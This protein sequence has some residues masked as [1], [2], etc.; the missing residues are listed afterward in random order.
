MRSDL[1]MRRWPALLGAAAMLLAGAAANAKGK[2][3]G[4]AIGK[5]RWDGKHT[6]LVWMKG[7]YSTAQSYSMQ[8]VGLV[9]EHAEGKVSFP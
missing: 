4:K 1:T 8:I 3:K 6:A 9:A 5:V 2:P 7:S